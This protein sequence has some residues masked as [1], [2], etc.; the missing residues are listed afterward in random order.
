MSQ[1]GSTYVGR[2]VTRVDAPVKAIG[3][4]VYGVDMELPGMLHGATL[5]SPYPH[6]KIM[7][8]DASAALKAPGVRAVVTG[9]DFPYLYGDVVRDQPFLAIDRVRFVGDP[10]A[11]VAAD[12]EACALEALGKIRVKYE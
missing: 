3:S 12:T 8:I 7:A 1:N 11:A 9:K 4:A 2:R 10:V 6:A 5:R